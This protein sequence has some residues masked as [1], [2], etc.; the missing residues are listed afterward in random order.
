M[1]CSWPCLVVETYLCS[2]RRDSV[3]LR[4]SPHRERGEDR[5]TGAEGGR[6]SRLNESVIDVT[7]R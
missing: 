5:D 1:V 4:A 3:V 7:I 6:V 2:A